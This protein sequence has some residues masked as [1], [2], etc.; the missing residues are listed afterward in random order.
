M[1]G[2]IILKIKKWKNNTKAPKSLPKKLYQK[3]KIYLSPKN[4]DLTKTFIVIVKTFSHVSILS[5]IAVVIALLWLTIAITGYWKGE[6]LAQEK[7]NIFMKQGCNYD[8]VTGWYSCSQLVT[9]DDKV[10]IEGYVIAST[11]TKVAFF[12]KEGSTIREIKENDR[13]VRPR[14]QVNPKTSS[15]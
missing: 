12:N 4:N 14:H 13:I 10:I 11:D 7:H 8:D 1:F 6:E 3:L 9:K 15:D 5:Y 2:F